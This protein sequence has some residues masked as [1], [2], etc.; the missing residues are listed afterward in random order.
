M[1]GVAE[2]ALGGGPAEVAGF[3]SGSRKGP[4]NTAHVAQGA[5]NPLGA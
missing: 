4:A 3:C 1:G 2:L 5:R